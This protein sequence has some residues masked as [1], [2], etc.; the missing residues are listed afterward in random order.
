MKKIII[1]FDET[2]GDAN[3][4]EGT[5]SELVAVLV[6]GGIQLTRILL[7]SIVTLIAN[8]KHPELILSDLFKSLAIANQDPVALEELEE[9]KNNSDEIENLLGKD[10][11]SFAKVSGDA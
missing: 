8:S 10:L 4:V 6:A 3:L 2:N 9:A 5:S 11:A 7:D 1:E